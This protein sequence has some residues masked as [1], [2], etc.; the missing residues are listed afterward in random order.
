MN[1]FLIDDWKTVLKKS[2]AV[3]M[4]ALS[5][6]FGLMEQNSAEVLELVTFLKPYVEAGAF[7]KLS[8]VFAVLAILGRIKRQP[9]MHEKELT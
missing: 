9:S 7:G 8:T 2:L 1:K 5:A 4:A 6:I 3:L